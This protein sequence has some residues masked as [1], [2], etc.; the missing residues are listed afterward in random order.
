MNDPNKI[1]GRE[2][3]PAQPGTTSLSLVEGVRARDPEAWERLAYLYGPL[4]YGWCRHRGLQ[5]PD[6][7]D[8]MQDVFMTV[9]ARIADFHR[10]TFRGWLWTITRNKLG[11]W[12]RRHGRQPQAVGGT[13]AQQQLLEMPAAG[14]ESEG[15]V[16]SAGIGALFRRGL[17]LIRP[18][19]EERTWQAF[20][21]VAME[22]QDPGDVAV[23]LGLSRN[24]VYVAKSRVLRRLREVL[25]ED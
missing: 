3:K 7:K 15:D 9:A 13:D 19:F 6:A 14:S 22:G 16:A 2:A 23:A 18:E 4:V 11:D 20:W 17:E 10:E 21:R 25:G 1:S 8:V 24:A 5:H 12:I